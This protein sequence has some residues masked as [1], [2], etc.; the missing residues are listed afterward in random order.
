MAEKL[1]V[2]PQMVANWT[3]GRNKPGSEW[4]AA[5]LTATACNG[6]WLLTGI[7]DAFA[8]PDLGVLAGQSTLDQSRQNLLTALE[9]TLQA[10]AALSPILT[11]ADRKHIAKL[12]QK[13]QAE[14]EKP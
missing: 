14:I 13:L 4:L 2:S 9:L 3:S 8:E 6:N 11:P 10:I 1:G 12:I 7:G 5:I